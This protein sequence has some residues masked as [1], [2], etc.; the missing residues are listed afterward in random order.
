MH[1]MEVSE[2]VRPHFIPDG[3]TFDD[4]PPALR[5]AVT[6]LIEPA[7]RELVLEAP[8]ALE[9]AAGSSLVFLMWIELLDQ[10][11]IASQHRGPRTAVSHPGD[12][13]GARDEQIARHLKVISAKDRAANFILRMK[14]YRAKHEDPFQDPF[15]EQFRN[16]SH[17]PP[18]G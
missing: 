18:K 11:E 2:Q 4:L 17:P 1:D 10:F 7:Y 13:T 14:V 6:G 5:A 12:D 3:L 8:N 9:R 15:I 16:G